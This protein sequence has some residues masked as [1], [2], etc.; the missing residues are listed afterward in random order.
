M[1]LEGFAY[2]SNGGPQAFYGALSGLAQE[3]LELGEGHLDPVEIR[4]LGREEKELSAG[5]LDHLT[6]SCPLWLERLDRYIREFAGRHNIRQH[7]TP[8]NR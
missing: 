7:K 8:S 6:D 2:A 4:A 1:G 3:C 5:S